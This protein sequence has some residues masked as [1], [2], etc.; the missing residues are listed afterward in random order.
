MA[1][2][3]VDAYANAMFE[4]AKAEGVLIEVE[5]ELFD[6]AQ[7]FKANDAL[8]TTLTD[9]AMP[10]DRRLAIID[11]LFK[12]S[13]SPVA[14]NLVSFVVGI[15]RARDL[16]DIIDRLVERAAAEK[17]K[18]VAEV[19][20]VIALTEEQRSR[21]AI[22]LG[23]A[24]GKQIEVKVVVDPAVLGGIVAQIGDQVIDGT[25]RTRLDQLRAGIQ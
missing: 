3:R 13:I 2:E 8:R 7:A 5:N 11:D 1:D 16:P 6:F 19:R 12:N 15:G 21:L 20:S 24:T 23:Q 17:D 10:V 22:A 25:V 14:P 4:V 9:A 18:A